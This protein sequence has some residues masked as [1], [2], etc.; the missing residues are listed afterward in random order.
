MR[1]TLIQIHLW[2]GITIGLIWAV[3]G[4]TGSVLVFFR[5]IHRWN[6]PEP[7]H[8]SLASL[9]TI[10]ANAS[11]AA[12]GARITRL[13]VTDGN[14]DLIYAYRESAEKQKPAVLMDAA[15]GRVLRSDYMAPTS[16]AGN[17]FVFWLNNL[18]ISLLTGRTGEVFVATSGLFL[19]SA[20]VL[21]LTIG[22]PPR[23][24]WKAAFAV[25]RWRKLDHQLYGWH[26]A[27]GLVAGFLIIT[28]SLSGFY[29]AF[30]PAVDDALAKVVPFERHY[31]PTPAAALATE[32]VSVQ[33][34]ADAAQA[35]FPNGRWARIYMPTKS[36]P[37]YQVRLHQPGES[38]V[39]LG[40]TMV[41]VDPA[42]GR[43]LATYDPLSAPLA[44]RVLDAAFPFHNGELA[45]L[46]GR[47]LIAISGLLLPAFYVTG[48]MAW[49][50]KRRKRRQRL[51]IQ[52]A[53]RA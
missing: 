3:Q 28:I 16:P 33:Q 24:G 27:V 22:W 2:L 9:D 53:M 23:R 38:R 37:V 26:R 1:R 21:G 30:E 31:R 8:G 5:E 4:L 51:A 48:L 40:K 50:R 19:V 11:A 45:G 29:F 47:I 18:H 15:T 17:V 36:S 25:Q 7:T 32:Q 44:N 46:P 43:V 34:A 14:R 10:V 42:D 12:G 20:C 6:A 52:P 39:W 41:W 35:R 49:W 13:A